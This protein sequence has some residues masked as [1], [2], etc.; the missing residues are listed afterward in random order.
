VQHLERADTL[1]EL[2]LVVLQL[3][4][5]NAW[6]GIEIRTAL[7]NAGQRFTCRRKYEWDLDLSLLTG[8]IHLESHPSLVI[9][10]RDRPA[11]GNTRYG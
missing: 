4:A 8:R 3:R 5:V 1:G 9:P 7:T 11:L 10:S 6:S 2:P